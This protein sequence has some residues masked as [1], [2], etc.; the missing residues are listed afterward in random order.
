M[1]KKTVVISVTNDLVTDQRVKR[2]I[3]VFLEKGYDV[4]FV[5]RKLKNSLEI[6]RIY[7]TVRFKLWFNKGFLFY[8]NYNIR[9]FFFLLFRRFDLYLSND[10]DTLL[11]N[12][13][14]ARWRAKPLIYDSHEYFLGVPEIQGRP[15]VKAVWRWIE[16]R[17]LPKVD[18]FITVNQSIKNLYE[19]DYGIRATVIRNI[20][21]SNKPSS[22]SSRSQLGLPE[23]KFIF[24]NQGAG[25][26]VD[27]GMEEFLEALKVLDDCVLLLVGKGDVYELLK[28]KAQQMGISDRVI[29]VSPKPYLDMLQYTFNADCGLSLDKG[30]N[31]NYQFSLPNKLF[32][33]IKA[34]IPVLSS[35]VIEVK[36]LVEHY[37]IGEV[38]ENHNPNTIADSARRIMVKSKDHFKPGLEKA[39]KENSWE[40]ERQS[41]DKLIQEIE[42]R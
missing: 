39:A 41:L 36:N 37:R 6:D 14:I 26:N 24:I 3:E 2:S 42:Q 21:D 28:A 9:L 13:I 5:G 29:F 10:L 20:S 40:L 15:I 18:A 31:P 19:K 23:D 7:E 35:N 38:V 25:I 16:K 30:S 34:G 4:C 27:R 33:Y 1:N 12:S 11:P 32:D 17:C 8:A 22:L